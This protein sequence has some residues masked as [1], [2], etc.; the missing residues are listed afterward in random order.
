MYPLGIR[1]VSP[2][3]RYARRI[4]PVLVLGVVAV[5]LMVAVVLAFARMAWRIWRHNEPLEPG[6]SYS[7]QAFGRYG[8]PRFEDEQPDGP[9]ARRSR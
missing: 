9:A 6:G 3:A 1:Q 2:E 4:G 8:T 5:V 7:R